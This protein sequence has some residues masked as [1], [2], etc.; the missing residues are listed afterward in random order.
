[1]KRLAQF[2]DDH[3]KAVAQGMR[4][5]TFSKLAVLAA[6]NIAHELFLAEQ[7]RTEKEAD[8]ERRMLSL[9]ESIEEQVQSALP[10]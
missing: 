8:V 5:A 2:V 3:M 6:V 10:R 9:M 7:Q 4:T 1:V